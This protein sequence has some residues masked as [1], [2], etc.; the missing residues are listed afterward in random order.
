MRLSLESET[1]GKTKPGSGALGH[2]KGE[3]P[4]TWGGHGQGWRR[5]GWSLCLVTVTVMSHVL[6]TCRRRHLDQGMAKSPLGPAP[7][8]RDLW[9]SEMLVILFT[10][11]S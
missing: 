7:Q 11:I 10:D 3:E 1:E 8:F 4:T 9:E 6:F 5:S 2:S